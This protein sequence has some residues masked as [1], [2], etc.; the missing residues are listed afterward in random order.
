M[1]T[2]LPFTL[3]NMKPVDTGENANFYGGVDFDWKNYEEHRPIYPQK[4]YDLLFEF[5]AR[6]GAQPAAWEQAVDFGTGVG[7]II[8]S[9]LQRFEKVVGSD[10]NEAQID[11]ARTRLLPTYGIDRVELHVGPAERCDWIKDGTADLVIAA[12]AVHWFD[13]QAW[14][15]QAARLLKPGGTLAFWIYK[16]MTIIDKEKGEA[17]SLMRKLEEKRG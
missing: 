16:P 9:L 14:I 15:R 5:H 13:S 10:L 7:Q 8:P 6:G 12:T 1:N 3:N 17:D 4:L 11:I 2:T